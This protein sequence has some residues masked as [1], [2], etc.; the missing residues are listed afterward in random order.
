MQA[1][2]S[3]AGFG[4]FVRHK[5]TKMKR[6][7]TELIAMV[8]IVAAVMF[9]GCTE[10][11]SDEKQVTELIQKDCKYMNDGDWKSMYEQYSPGYRS[12]YPYNAFAEDMNE[13]LALIR[14]LGGKGKC[15]QWRISM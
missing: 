6:K 7:T 14:V 13:G 2:Y 12:A 1:P 15:S 5:V 8:V 3:G 11:K 4:G 10:L 9:A